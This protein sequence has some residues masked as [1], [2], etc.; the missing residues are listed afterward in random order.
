M[1]RKASEYWAG[2][3]SLLCE[4]FKIQSE[5]EVAQSCLTFCDPL[6]CSHQV[7]LSMGFSRQEYWSGLLLSSMYISY[8]W[9]TCLFCSN[10]LQN[11]DTFLVKKKNYQYSSIKYCSRLRFDFYYYCQVRV[12]L[13]KG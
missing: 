5:S 10:F 2:I 3:L 9:A 8:S 12:D 11:L 1:S 13:Y 4:I 6:D 7:L